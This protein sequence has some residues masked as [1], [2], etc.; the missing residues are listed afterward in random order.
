MAAASAVVV[1][2]EAVAAEAVVGEVN[3]ARI[4]E[5]ILAAS[6]NCSSCLDFHHQKSYDA[7]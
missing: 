2:A 3:L 1:A 4:S 5:T 6:W 7:A